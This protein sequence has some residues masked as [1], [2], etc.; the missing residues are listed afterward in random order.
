MVNDSYAAGEYA[1][2]ARYRAA[3]ESEEAKAWRESLNPEEYAR[4]KRYGLLE[5]QLDSAPFDTK[6]DSLP[7]SMVVS[8]K[9]PF[10]GRGEARD[11]E[12]DLERLLNTCC[13]P[14]HRRALEVFLSSGPIKGLRWACLRY[15]AGHGTV[16]SQATR[17]G[18][19]KQAFDYHVRQLKEKL[20]L[21]A[22]GNSRGEAA[23]LAYALTNRRNANFDSPP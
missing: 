21:P 8:T 13:S 7:Q 15:L 14:R 1:R 16:K 9:N 18:M 3:F 19:S 12:R 2:A 6:V 20:D 4:A 17:F 5:P 23:S 22:L 11:A 10:A